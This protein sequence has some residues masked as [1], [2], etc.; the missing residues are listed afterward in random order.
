M[1][2]D[3]RKSQG[4]QQKKFDY[5]KYAYILKYF[6]KEMSANEI[7]FYFSQIFSGVNSNVHRIGQ[8]MKIYKNIFQTHEQESWKTPFKTYSFEGELLLHPSTKKLWENKLS[9]FVSNK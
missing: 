7:N 9:K 5:V 6:E 4:L 1:I 8:M 2:L 3:F